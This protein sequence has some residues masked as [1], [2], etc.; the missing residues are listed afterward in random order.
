MKE[1]F[2]R[3]QTKCWYVKD[4]AGRFLRLAKDKTEAFAI[5]HKM[6]AAQTYQG[7]GATVRGLLDAFLDEIEGELSAD[8]YA[9][10]RHYA[11]LFVESHGGDL[12]T[13]VKPSTVSKWLRSPKPDRNKEE[14]QDKPKTITWGASSQRHA[15]AMLKRCWKWA[16]DSGH[17]TKN[18]LAALKLQECEY[19][20]DVIATGTHDALVRHCM[21]SPDARP[22]ALY[23]IASRSGARPQQI[24]DVTAKHVSRDFTQWVFKEHKTSAKTGRPLVIYLSPC[25]Q[26]L[27]RI[28]AASHPTGPLFRNSLGEKWKKDTVAQRMRR[29]RTTLKL[30]EST[31]AYLYRHSMATDA[32]LSGQSTAVVAQ[33]L[34][35]TDT[36]MV[37]QVYGHLDRHSQFLTD[38]VA[39]TAASRMP[40]STLN[41]M[42]RRLQ[43][44]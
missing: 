43:S 34:G 35:H 14:D 6:R 11:R 21:A 28:L 4:E 13:S 18:T 2:F 31:V 20:D 8:R 22:F 39:A 1:P 15:A 42:P 12:V 5:W 33:L 16:H 44:G 26:T 25:L 9:A 7:D 30:P 23:L 3:K 37:S 24:R 36:R 10:L 19:R 40:S 17:T 29:L 32:L 38:A 41:E 27:T